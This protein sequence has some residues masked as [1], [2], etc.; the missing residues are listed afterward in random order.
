MRAL[1]GAKGL[2][3]L[4]FCAV[5][6]LAA[7]T[8]FGTQNISDLLRAP[9]LGEGQGEVQEALALDLGDEPEYKFPKEGDWRSP[10][11]M[12]DLDG[13]GVEEGV[14]LYS[15]PVASAPAQ[16]SNVYLAVMKRAGDEWRVAQKIEGEGVEVAS[17]EVAGLL[18]DGA[19]QVLVG[20]A[21][22]NMGSKKLALYRWRDGAL[23]SDKVIAY[24]RY[25]LA[26]FTG[27][28]REDLVVV[29]SDNQTTGLVLQHIPVVDGEFDVSPNNGVSMGGTNLVSCQGLYPS[30]SE[31]GERLIVADCQDENSMLVS[32]LYYMGERVYEKPGN[33]DLIGGTARQNPLLH[34]R[35]ID[36]D[37]RVEVPLRVNDEVVVTPAGDKNMEFVEWVD[38]TGEAPVRK[39][40]GLLDSGRGVYV[41]LPDAWLQ[42]KDGRDT[43]SV[44][45]SDGS[46][47]G[48]WMLEDAASLRVLLSLRIYEPGAEPPVGAEQVS[49][50]SNAWLIRAAGLSNS[51]KERIHVTR[52]N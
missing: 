44:R 29:S 34:S 4:L 17:L 45:V 41:S 24:S 38:F 2:L 8:P 13:D 32:Q 26:D 35:D 49:E 18:D 40:F 5:L 1:R 48:E 50:A 36:E 39:Q 20:Y 51:E 6:L 12:A 11:I 25:E 21:S 43:L 46:A 27:N 7:C 10:L 37:G 14:L 42:N 3:A 31:V 30:Q 9:A 52:M 15:L 47:E 23:Q 33:V 28:G 16:S 22:A 19:R